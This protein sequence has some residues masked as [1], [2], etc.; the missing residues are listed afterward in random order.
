MI[1]AVNG[2]VP[3]ELVLGIDA[4]RDAQAEAPTSTDHTHDFE[5]VSFTMEAT[6]NGDKLHAF[7]ESLPEG[8]LRA[9]GV[10][11]LAEQPARRTIYQR[12]GKRWSFSAAEPWGDET[13]HSSLVFIGPKG[14]LDPSVLQAG[15]DAC[16]AS[17][18][19]CEERR[20]AH[21]F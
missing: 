3:V 16:V 10:L 19:A 6:L 17:A 21:Q 8:L 11:N 18:T 13:P 12:V 15:L 1:E 4:R 5:S 9:K 7:L 20:P 14:M 2:D